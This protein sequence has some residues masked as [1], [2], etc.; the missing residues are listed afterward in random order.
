MTGGDRQRPS[1]PLQGA[2]AQWGDTEGLSAGNT[3]Q[4]MLKQTPLL[5]G[6]TMTLR[7]RVRRL[8]LSV[9][10]AGAG[11][12]SAGGG[13]GGGEMKQDLKCILDVEPTGTCNFV[14]TA[15]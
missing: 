1:R 2:G 3:L 13:H 4:L 14:L 8:L 10:Q 15:T 11:G 9:I 7:D 12:D 5:T 6:R